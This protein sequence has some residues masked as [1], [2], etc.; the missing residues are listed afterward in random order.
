MAADFDKYIRFFAADG[1]P[2]VDRS[3]AQDRSLE[4]N[5]TDDNS[6]GQLDLG[7]FF[8]G[9]DWVYSGYTVTIGGNIFG[10]FE[11]ATLT[12]V[13]AIPYSSTGATLTAASI[14]AATSG[15][16]AEAEVATGA[17]NCFLTGTMIA[18]PQGETTVEALGIGDEILTADGRT[19]RVKWVGRQAFSRLANLPMPDRRAPVC[20]AAGALGGGLPHTDLFV[21]ADHGLIV[22]GLLIN[23]GALVNHNTIRFVPMSEMPD[24]FTY[25]HVETDAHDEI[26]ANGAPVETLIDYIGRRGFDNHQ[27]YLDLYG[28]E[29][30]IPEMKRIRISAQRQLPPHLE[31]RFGIMPYSQQIAV[32]AA[33]LQE[34]LARQAA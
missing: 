25:F 34:R 2:T 21:T 24:A 32:E 8:A 23:A 18:T 7:D 26:L 17:V 9:G 10:I 14:D 5:V 31:Q 30:I 4:A 6:S 11:N 16:F 13:F 33:L 28:Q 22:D 1:N 27:E 19:V 3:P 20:I 15:D 12:G 29:R